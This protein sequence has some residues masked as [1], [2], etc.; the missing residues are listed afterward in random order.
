MPLYSYKCIE[1]NHIYNESRKINENQKETHCP[2]CG[3]ILR[4]A[5]SAPAIQ[6]NG[7][8]FYKTS[9]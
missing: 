1:N 4:R 5:Y 3:S 9:S 8:G 6:F 7:S 2:E